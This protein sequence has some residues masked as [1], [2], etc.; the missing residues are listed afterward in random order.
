MRLFRL[1]FYCLLFHAFPFHSFHFSSLFKV[2]VLEYRNEYHHWKI[3]ALLSYHSNH[4]SNFI[5]G[6]IDYQKTEDK[7]YA[8]HAFYKNE[9]SK[10]IKLAWCFDSKYRF[11]CLQTRCS[12]LQCFCNHYRRAATGCNASVAITDMLHLIAILL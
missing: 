2:C 12:W 4:D 11:F 9:K 10:L 5:F 6:D 1:F 3:N 7:T 8:T